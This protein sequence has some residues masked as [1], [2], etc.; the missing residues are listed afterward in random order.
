PDFWHAEGGID[1][2]T[3]DH[4]GRDVDFD[5]QV[6]PWDFVQLQPTLPDRRRLGLDP[7]TLIRF[8]AFLYVFADRGDL[9]QTG[10]VNVALEGVHLNEASDA[11]L[12]EFM[13]SSN[14]GRHNFH[15]ALVVRD[16]IMPVLQL[17]ERLEIV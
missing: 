14:W 5:N 17:I 8:D 13:Q 6:R 10:D 3:L 4:A 11:L 16:A 15:P 1:R 2:L 9:A 12:P 7:V